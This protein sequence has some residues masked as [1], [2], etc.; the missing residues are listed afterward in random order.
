MHH[1]PVHC[2]CRLLRYCIA[3]HLSR[4][5]SNSLLPMSALPSI[6]FS[7]PH[8]SSLVPLIPSP[9]LSPPSLH[10]QAWASEEARIGSE[11][12]REAARSLF[13]KCLRIAP[14]SLHALQVRKHTERRC[15]LHPQSNSAIKCQATWP[16]PTQCESAV[17][18]EYFLITDS[19]CEPVRNVVCAHP[20]SPH[21][22][23]PPLT[24]PSSGLGSDGVSSG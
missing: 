11:E 24:P 10:L 5:M 12:S 14:Q 1:Q 18:C 19:L 23:P 17:L 16:S 20:S 8:L 7:S 6:R 9:L 4:A 15:L 22:P 21:T 2:G 3:L 13:R